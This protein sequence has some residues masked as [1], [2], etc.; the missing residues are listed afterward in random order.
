MNKKLTEIIF[1]LD[2]S[3]SM[4]SVRSDVVSGF[5]TFIQDQKELPGEAT[6]TFVKFDN[7]YNVVTQSALLENVEE[8]S[9][10]TYKPTGTTA[11]LDAVGKTINDVV[12]RHATLEKSEVPG[13]VIL[14]VFTDGEE[15]SSKE[16]REV[17]K[18]SELVSARE[19]EGWEILFMGADIDAW[20]DGGRMGFSKSRGVDKSDMLLNMS[21]MSNYTASYRKAPVGTKMDMADVDV[22]FDMSKEDLDKQMK[23]LKSKK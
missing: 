21:K 9:N 15:N 3:G 6:F 19:D 4:G 1:V 10:Q 17:K 13:K 16:F 20:A 14:V 11:L 7:R 8:L 2:E 5:N 18:I 23:D 22:T 12:S